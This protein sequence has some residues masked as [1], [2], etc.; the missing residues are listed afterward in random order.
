MRP[1][2]CVRRRRVAGRGG[3][4]RSEFRNCSFRHA[5]AIFMTTVRTVTGRR[6][7]PRPRHR[8]DRR[9][10]RSRGRACGMAVVTAPFSGYRRAP[11]G[12]DGRAAVRK[13][14]CRLCVY[15]AAARCRPITTGHIIE[16][17]A[18]SRPTWRPTATWSR[19]T[20]PR[21]RPPPSGHVDPRRKWSIAPAT[22][23]PYRTRILVR[24]PPTPAKFN[25]TVVVEWM[26]VSAGESSPGLELPQPR[27]DARGLRLRGG[28]GAGARRSTGARRSSA[29]PRRGSGRR[30]ARPLRHVAPPR[31]PV[32]A[33]HVRPDR[34]G[35][36]GQ[37]A[38]RSWA[39][40]IPTTWWRWASR[41]RPFT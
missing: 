25:G 15:A 22:T 8:H 9:R 31:G 29:P 5:F 33:R 10:V 13:F 16:P 35:R 4:L 12:G 28:V 24:R 14:H 23:A 26:N 6:P 40:S 39:V 2:C 19:S 18:A 34:P 32:L 3:A 1:I 37:P 7:P 21:A 20:S 17:G 27:V 41:S 30:R 11:G 36:A 38:R